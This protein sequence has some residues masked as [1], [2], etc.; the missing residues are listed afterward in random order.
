MSEPDAPPPPPPPSTTSTKHNTT[1]ATLERCVAELRNL[2]Y[3]DTLV[4]SSLTF[5]SLHLVSALV[6]DLVALA[7]SASTSTATTT[8]ATRHSTTPE[9]VAA[10][11]ERVARAEADN[12]V[13]IHELSASLDLAAK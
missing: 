12:L 8:P 10:L 2:G 3:D 7:S 11:R 9:D 6:E 1:Q 5:S 13:L 4:T